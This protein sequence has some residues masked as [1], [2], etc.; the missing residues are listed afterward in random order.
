MRE[1]VML[2]TKHNQ[3]NW[4]KEEVTKNSSLP[5]CYHPS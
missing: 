3:F 4:S 5:W 2:L 1:I